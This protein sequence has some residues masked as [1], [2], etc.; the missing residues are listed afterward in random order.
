MIVLTSYVSTILTLRGQAHRAVEAQHALPTRLFVI[1]TRLV[2]THDNILPVP[3]PPT[4]HNG[5]VCFVGRSGT[6]DASRFIDW[7]RELDRRY[8]RA[9]TTL[10]ATSRRRLRQRRL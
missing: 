7:Y 4:P 5:L 2:I 9:C 3:I 1:I 6:F 8:E 10:T